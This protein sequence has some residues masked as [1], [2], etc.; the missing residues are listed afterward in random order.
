MSPRP[1]FHPGTDHRLHAQLA[2]APPP[3]RPSPTP[4]RRPL[5]ITEQLS[6]APSPFALEMILRDAAL[7]NWGNPKTRATW[8]Q[9]AY[10]RDCE[11]RGV[12]P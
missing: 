12:L 3:P 4:P 2:L 7:F 6:R 11:R 1:R 9:T 8:A 5:S 10:V